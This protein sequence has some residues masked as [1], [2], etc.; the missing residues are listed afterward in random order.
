MKALAVVIGF[1]LAVTA[2]ALAVAFAFAD[3]FGDYLPGFMQPVLGGPQLTIE[4][5]ADGVE[6]GQA[7]AD[8]IKVIER[9]L[10]DLGV[11]F[12]VQPQDSDR[13]LLS[14]SKSADD[15][16]VMNVVT[17]RGRLEFRF[18]EVTPW[19]NM[20]PEQAVRGEPPAD[21]EE[22]YGRGSRGERLPYRVYKRVMLTGRDLV[23]AQPGFDVRT[24]EPIVSFRFNANGARQFAQATQEN[25]GKP[26]A[27]VLDN[28]VISAP[29]I[30]EPILGG[31]GQISGNFTVQSA[32][33]L[34]ILL[35]SGELPARLEVIQKRMPRVPDRQ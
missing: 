27:I 20:T 25:V 2:A 30:R 15:L 1:V 13:I 17:R 7:V 33:D 24:N 34:A 23:D 28:E 4:V 3:R 18:V 32:N 22:L 16:R 10:K 29:I 14:L 12:T 5:E 8:S 19:A 9:R 26:F 6:I 31:S 35:R 11:H 21:A